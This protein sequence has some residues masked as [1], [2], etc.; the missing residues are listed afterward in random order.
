MADL[1]GITLTSYRRWENGTECNFETLI[2]IG[3]Y[4]NVSTDDLLKRDLSQEK[5]IGKHIDS[6]TLPQTEMEQLKSIY[7]LLQQQQKI[8]ERLE[9]KLL[10]QEAKLSSI[11]ME[12]DDIKRR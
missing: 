9:T 6:L 10:A 1:F 5:E 8:I 12:I 3:E 11:R 4:F 7:Q 2:K